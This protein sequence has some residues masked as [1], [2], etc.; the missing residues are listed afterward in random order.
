M[1]HYNSCQILAWNRFRSMQKQKNMFLE[2]TELDN[3]TNEGVR[4]TV[5]KQN[6]QS[7][8]DSHSKL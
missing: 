7:E 1:F 5:H 6:I 3:K 2:S 4:N 8:M